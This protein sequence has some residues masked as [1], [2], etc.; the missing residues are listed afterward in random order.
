MGS[1]LLLSFIRIVHDPQSVT[2]FWKYTRLDNFEED[3]SN[4][5]QIINHG[6][7]TTR[8]RNGVESQGVRIYEMRLD[9][10]KREREGRVTW[11]E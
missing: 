9:Y 5:Q 7:Q 6:F 4:S 11:T 1:F 10:T 2:P 8:K 3:G